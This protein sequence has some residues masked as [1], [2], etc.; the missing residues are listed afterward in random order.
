MRAVGGR[1]GDTRHYVETLSVPFGCP[2]AN[3]TLAR[4]SHPLTPHCSGGLTARLERQ[5]YR[6]ASPQRTPPRP[7][8][9]TP[10]TMPSQPPHSR[11]P[12]LLPITPFLRMRLPYSACSLR[13]GTSAGEELGLSDRQPAASH[14]RRY[15]PSTPHPLRTRSQPQRTLSWRAHRKRSA[16]PPRTPRRRPRAWRRSAT[17]GHRDGWGPDIVGVMLS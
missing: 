1:G 16:P 14:N 3:V 5:V 2:R 7:H 10:I 12:H 9:P 15:S 6:I 4:S 8:A 17:S 11:R 13:G